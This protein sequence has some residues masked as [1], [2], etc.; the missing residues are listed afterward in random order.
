MTYDN[1]DT[2]ADGVIDSPIDNKSVSTKD[3]N[4]DEVWAH[5]FA[6]SGDGSQSNPWQNG[7]YNA[8]NSG[9][10]HIILKSR[11]GSLGYFA[12][13]NKIDPALLP[14]QFAI[15]GPSSGLCRITNPNNLDP[16]LDI[17]DGSI[18]RATLQGFSANGRLLKGSNTYDRDHLIFDVRADLDGEDTKNG[19]RPGVLDISTESG[20]AS[21][22]FRYGLNIIQHADY[23]AFQ[24][25]NRSDHPESGYAFID[26]GG[27]Q[28]TP[29][30]S[31]SI[32][33]Q[34]TGAHRAAYSLKDA[35]QQYNG[36]GDRVLQILRDGHI[37]VGGATSGY[38]VNLRDRFPAIYLQNADSNNNDL[39]SARLQLDDNQLAFRGDGNEKFVEMKNDGTGAFRPA[40]QD[41]SALNLDA[42]HDGWKFHHNGNSQINADGG[43]TSTPGEYYWDNSNGEFKSIYQY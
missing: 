8:L 11:G 42:S 29:L 12:E 26:K 2:N 20:G 32:I 16:H 14:D 33:H 31:A 41:I 6:D 36:S 34:M 13:H 43:T 18:S 40:A 39:K 15:M 27:T 25:E 37:R 10:S 30:S 21:N 22:N 38:T 5:R 4:N 19:D 23:K 35:N 9:E 1:T 28:S 7:I 17:A 3:I 24:A